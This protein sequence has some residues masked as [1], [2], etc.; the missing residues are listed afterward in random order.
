[1]G[2]EL[3]LSQSGGHSPDQAHRYGRL[4]TMRTS[5][6]LTLKLFAQRWLVME[7]AQDIGKLQLADLCTWGRKQGQIVHVVKQLVVPV[8]GIYGLALTEML[9]SCELLCRLTKI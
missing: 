5:R 7:A 6:Y 2:K 8:W 4:D 3:H 9:S 1:M